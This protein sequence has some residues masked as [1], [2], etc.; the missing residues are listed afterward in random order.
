MSGD[1]PGRSI[2]SEPKQSLLGRR[3]AGIPLW[4]WMLI[5]LLIVLLVVAVVTNS[6]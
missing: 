5:D 2:V 3:I 6:L 1:D 4:V